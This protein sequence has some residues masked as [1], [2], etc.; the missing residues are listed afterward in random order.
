MLQG[1]LTMSKHL[2]SMSNVPLDMLVPVDPPMKLTPTMSH[3][4]YTAKETQTLIKNMLLKVLK[5]LEK[6]HQNVM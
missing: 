2:N 1:T 6:L 4:V 3:N 5:Q